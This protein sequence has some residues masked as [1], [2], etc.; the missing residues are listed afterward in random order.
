MSATLRKHRVEELDPANKAAFQVR[1]RWLM[2]ARDPRRGGKQIPP[3]DLD[4]LI[5]L[6]RAGR[7]FGKTLSLAQWLWWEC[8]R[9]P[10]LIGHWIG[11]TVGDAKGTGF[12]GPA[13]LKAA[14]P[15]E[16]LYRGSWEYAYR[17]SNP[18]QLRFSNGSLIR[19]FGAQEEGG[20]LRGPQ[21]GALAGDELR[22]WEKPAGNLEIALNNALYGLRLP[23]PDGTPARALLATTPRP[24]A[25]LKRFEKR[26]D[27]RVVT[28]SSRENLHNLSTS[29]RNQIMSQEGT[30]MGRQEID[31]IYIDEESD[32][33]IIKRQW[34]KLW[35]AEKKLPEFAFVIESY[36]TATSEENFDVKK[37]ETD[38]TACIVLGIFNVNA[39][40][41]EIERKKMGLRNRYAAV[42][43]EAWSERLGLPE[44]LDKARAQHRVKWG[45]NKK[46]S[47][48]VLIE[49]KSSGPSMRQML[50]TYGVSSWPYNPGKQS[51]TMRLH[52]AAPVLQQGGLFV[53]ESMRPDRKG[54]PRD[55]VEPFLEQ[56]CAFAGP[57]SVEH[58]DY[59]DAASSAIAYLKDRDMLQAK[60]AVEFLDPEE[61]K[62]K[63]Q[64]EAL[65][66]KL[67]SERPKGNPY[68]M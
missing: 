65:E 4:W 57:G 38:P 30:L 29:F 21:C 14:I 63:E 43:C 40:F 44:L 13:G 31:A 26:P 27:V 37:Q 24:I 32:L 54:Q 51:K 64:R 22:E 12:E 36:D 10:S 3:D 49:D 25:F 2:D 67:R 56:L 55:W 50:L 66:I 61:K 9:M 47:D 48:I 5:L 20:R 17:S 53:P 60:P 41:T 59:V 18:L 46:R 16:C 42:L 34:I 19:G 11:P 8:W 6:L 28:G 15:A 62:E 52:A 39:A 68:S 23:Y 58:D 7:G 1:H 45:A 35:P 33:S